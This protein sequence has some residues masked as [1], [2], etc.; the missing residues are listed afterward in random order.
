M[1]TRHQPKS[2]VKNIVVTP[3]TRP[4]LAPIIKL[5]ISEPILG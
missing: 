5:L 4:S 3:A 1:V 2:L